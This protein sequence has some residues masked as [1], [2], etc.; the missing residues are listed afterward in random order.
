MLHRLMRL[1]LISLLVAAGLVAGAESAMACSCMIPDA[2]AL[3][4][5]T[6]GAF[7][8]TLI[9]A[10]GQP[11]G[12]VVS[13]ADQVPYVFEIDGAY[14]GDLDSP[15]TVFSARSGASCGLEMGVGQQASLFIDGDGGGQ[16]TGS[17]CSTMGPE[18]LLDGPF[19]P[20]AFGESTP[21][22]E[23]S[24]ARW[25]LGGLLG[26]AGVALGISTLRKRRPAA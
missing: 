25:T 23:T 22:G 18:A 1:A 4:G 19:E 10:P 20:I 2:Q 9:K 16:W 17:L 14:K 15:I 7:V 24:V 21:S 13:S 5:G 11:L 26:V 6:D 12:G 8:G 3:M